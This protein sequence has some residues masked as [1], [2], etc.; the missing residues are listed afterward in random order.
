[1]RCVLQ[2]VIKAS[3][4]QTL[5]LVLGPLLVFSQPSQDIPAATT[6][7]QVGRITSTGGTVRLLSD[8]QSSEGGQAGF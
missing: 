8:F 1:M 3:T 2:R 7:F 6:R 5:P 4:C